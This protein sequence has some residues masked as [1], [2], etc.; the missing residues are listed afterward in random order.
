MFA[1]FFNGKAAV[2]DLT[3]ETPHLMPDAPPRKVC[4]KLHYRF[5]ACTYLLFVAEF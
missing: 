4:E 5:A 2:R 3:K 1:F